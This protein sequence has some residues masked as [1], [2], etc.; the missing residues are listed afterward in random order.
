MPGLIGVH[1]LWE[2]ISGFELGPIDEISARKRHHLGKQSALDTYNVNMGD[3]RTV[4]NFLRY[5][6]GVDGICF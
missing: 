5:L 4:S 3:N 1:G 6:K 2:E